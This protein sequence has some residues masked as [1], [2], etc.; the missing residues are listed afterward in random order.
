MKMPPG[1]SK[2]T[3]NICCFFSNPAEGLFSAVSTQL[4]KRS[5]KMMEKHRQLLFDESMVSLFEN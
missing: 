5:Q 3:D 1:Q 4:V 2:Y